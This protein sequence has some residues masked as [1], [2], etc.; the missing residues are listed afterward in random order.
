MFNL[1]IAIKAQN[2]L[3]YEELGNTESPTLLPGLYDTLATKLQASITE[4][5]TEVDPQDPEPKITMIRQVNT[6]YESLADFEDD[7]F[8]ESWRAQ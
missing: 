4:A 2:G 3:I 8:R 1:H 7:L 6:F 5:G